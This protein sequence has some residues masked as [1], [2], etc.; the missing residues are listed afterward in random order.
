MIDLHF[1]FTAQLW[2]Y[3]GK[4]AWFFITL[5]QE[6][7]AQIKFFHQKRRGWGSVRVKAQIGTTVWETSIFPDSKAN[8]YIL[9][10]KAEV[11]KREKLVAGD[12]VTVKVNIT[13]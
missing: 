13:A 8:A 2:M 7:S 5:P 10:V 4:G 1:T 9:P 3:Q 6:D 12:A 11:R